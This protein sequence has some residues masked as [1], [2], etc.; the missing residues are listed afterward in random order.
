MTTKMKEKNGK[1]LIKAEL[2]NM[3]N[4]NASIIMDIMGKK[5]KHVNQ[6]V[7]NAPPIMRLKITRKTLMLGRKN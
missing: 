3:V 1:P 7:M 5:Y 6:P 4:R 2:R